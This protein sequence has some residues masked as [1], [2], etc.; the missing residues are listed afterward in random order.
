[1]GATGATGATGPSA[2]SDLRGVGLTADG[3]VLAPRPRMRKVAEVDHF[4]SGGLTA[5]IIGKLGWGLSTSGSGS[6]LTRTGNPL[7]SQKLQFASGGASGRYCS[8]YL[9]GSASE[10]LGTSANFAWAQ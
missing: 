1:Q 4:I 8:I 6:A 5:G 9:G 7:G 10:A 3:G 2:A